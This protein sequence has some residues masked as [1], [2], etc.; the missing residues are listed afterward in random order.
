[1]APLEYNVDASPITNVTLISCCHEQNLFGG[2]YS[3]N[4]LCH[5]Y[6]LPS[7]FRLHLN[8]VRKI[9]CCWK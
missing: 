3:G 8:K 4:L 5:Q 9:S 7:E 1:M 6:E 2:L